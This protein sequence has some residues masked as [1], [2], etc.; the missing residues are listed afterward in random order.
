MMKRINDFALVAIAVILLVGL[1]I[2]KD[3]NRYD[4]NTEQEI[5]YLLDKR[6]GKVWVSAIRG[7]DRPTDTIETSPFIEIKHHN[8]N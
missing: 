4:I 8:P 7:V 5:I 6:T 2:F 3:Y 1:F